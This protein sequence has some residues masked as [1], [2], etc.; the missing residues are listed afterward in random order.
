[1]PPSVVFTAL[2]TPADFSLPSPLP[3]HFLPGAAGQSVEAAVFRYLV[4]L[5]V[6]PDSSERKNTL[7]AC[8][9]R[10]TPLLMAMIA[11]SFHLVIRPLKIL[12]VTA[13]VRTSLSTPLRL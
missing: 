6:V 13:G 4:K 8:A 9:G 11:G 3:V 5:S 10:V 7:M 2:A 1:M 12:A